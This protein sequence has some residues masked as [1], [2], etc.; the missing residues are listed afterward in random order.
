MPGRIFRDGSK[1]FIYYIQHI[2]RRLPGIEG[3]YT[4]LFIKGCSKFFS[5]L[6]KLKYAGELD[7]IRNE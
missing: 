7:G 2:P 5:G 6:I 4:E 1:L 3:F